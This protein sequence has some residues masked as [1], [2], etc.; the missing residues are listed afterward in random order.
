MDELLTID[1]TAAFLHMS[2][3]TLL[4]LRGRGDFPSS[5]V[6]S[7]R[8]IFYRRDDLTGWVRGR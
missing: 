6:L 5:V 7:P 3:R 8:K 4:G 1:Q 2:R